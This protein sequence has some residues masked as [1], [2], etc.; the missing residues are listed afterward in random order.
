MKTSCMTN[1]LKKLAFPLVVCGVLCMGS[2]AR[3]QA[4][5]KSISTTPGLEN[6][7]LYSAGSEIEIKIG[8][9]GHCNMTNTGPYAFPQLRVVVNGENSSFAQMKAPP[10]YV[11][12]NRT[13]FYFYYKVLPGDMASPLKIY[14]QPSGYDVVANGYVFYNMT[15]TSNLVWKFDTNPLTS[16]LGDV[17]DLDFTAVAK[18]T[19]KTLAYDDAHSPVSVAATESVSWRVT[20]QNAISNSV[21]SF[22]VWPV[23]TNLVRVGSVPGQKA[24]LVSMPVGTTFVDFP[25][26]GLATGTTDIVAQRV[27]DY[28][29]SATVA[30]NA[31]TRTITVTVPPEPTVKVLFAGAETV[32]LPESP[33]LNTGSLTVELSQPFAQ[34]VWVRL[35]TTPSVQTNVAFVPAPYIVRVLAGSLASAPV[36]FSLPDGTVASLASGIVITP[37]VTNPAAASLFTRMKPGTVYVRNVKPTIVTPQPLV[38][39]PTVTRGEPYAFNWSVSDVPLDM[40]SGMTLVWNFGDGTPNVIVSNATGSVYHT[41][42]SPAVGTGTRTVTVTATDKDGGVSDPVIYN[43]TVVQPVPKPSVRIV[44]SAFTYDETSTNNTGSLNLVLSEAFTEDVWIQLTTSPAGQSNIV[45]GVTNAIRI[46]YGFLTNANP[47]KFSIP[48]GTLQSELAGIDIIPT[49]TNTLA[50]AYYTD[51]QPITLYAVNVRPKVDN[52]KARDLAA[53][54]L[55]PFNN[56]PM[57][58]P[59]AFSWTVADVPADGPTM[60]ISWLFDSGVTQ[61]TKTGT[62]LSGVVYPVFP[63][64]GD[65]TVTMQATDKDGGVSDAITFKITVTAPPPLPTVSIIPPAGPLYETD[66]AFTGSFIVHL[67]ETFTNTVTVALGVSPVNSLANGTLTLF[68]NR[69]YIAAGLQ[70]ATVRF[71]AKDGTV[72]SRDSGFIVTPTV[73]A[74]PAAV[75]KY[76]ETLTGLIQIINVAPVITTPAP[77]ATTNSVLS[78]AQGAPYTFYWNVNDVSIDLPG[79]LV[80]WYFGDGATAVMLG[81]S[82]QVAHTYTAVGDMV[83]RVVAQDKDGERNEVQFR[84]TVAQA[85]AINVT[86]IGPNL[87]ANYY[88]AAGLGNGMV[89]SG[90]ARS[91]QNRNNTYFFKYDPGITQ[92][93]LEAVPYKTAPLG[94]YYVTNFNNS[95]VAVV[96]TAQDLFDSFFYVWVGGTEQGLGA[97]NCVPGTALP[98][99]VVLMPSS[100]TGGTGTVPA[101]VDIREIS[102][103]F[104]REWRIADNMGDIN[105]DGIPDKIATRYNLPTLAGGTVVGGTPVELVNVKNF[106]S[107]VDAAGNVVGDFLPGAASGG[108]A[109][110]GGLSNV[111]ATI[112]SPFTALLEIRGFHPGLNSAGDRSDEDFGPGEIRGDEPGTDPTKTDTDGDL[113]PDGWEYYFWYHSI[114]EHATGLAYNPLDVSVGTVIPYKDIIIAFDPMVHAGDAVR[115]DLDNDGLSDLEELAMGTNPIN[116]DTD[117]D[118][119]CDGWEVLRG[120]NPNDSRD[121][122]NSSMNNPDGDYMAITT[123]PRQYVT[124]VNGTTTN[125][126]LATGA[127]IGSTSGVFTTWYHYGDTNA[128][129]AVGRLVTLAAGD[130]V[131]A[132]TTNNVLIMH[133]QVYQEFGFDP[134]TAWAGTVNPLSNPQRFPAW[135]A[136]YTAENYVTAPNTQPFTALDEYLLLKYMSELRLNGATAAM[137]AGN[138]GQKT[139]DWTSYSTHPKTPDSDVVWGAN[140]NV[141]KTDRMPDGWEMYVSAPQGWTRNYLMISPWDAYDGEWTIVGEDDLSNMREFHGTDCSGGYTNIALYGA[142]NPVVTIIRP[143]SD[144][145]WINKF[146]PTSPWIGDTDGD[147]IKDDAEMTFIYGA[148]P[149]VDNGTTCTPGGG[150]NPNTMDTDLDSLPDGWENAFVGTIPTAAPYSI[151]NGMDG[152]VSDYN[153][154]WDADGLLNYQEYW[155]QAVRGFRYDIPDEGVIGAATGNAGLPMDITFAAVDLF[156][157]VTNVWDAARKPWGANGPTLYVMLQVGP[158]KLYVGT[159][160]RDPDSDG[161]GMDDH[162]EMFHGLN[163]VLGDASLV[164]GDIVANAYIRNGGYTIDYGGAPLF[165]GNDW[166]GPL[167]PLDFMT[168]PWLAG[169]PEAD[170]DADGLRNLEEKLQPNTAAPAYS[171]TDPSPIW[172]TDYS[173]PE[174][175]TARFYGY[176]G[177][178]FWPPTLPPDYL[179]SY[180]MNEGYDTDN[181]GVSD[182]A[183]MMQTATTK[184]DPQNHD[185]PLRRQAMWFSG[186][187]SAAQTLNAFSFGEWAFRSFTVE[188]WA[189]PEVVNRD[190]VLVERPITYGPSDLSTAGLAV[191]ENFRI[192]VAADGRVYAMFQNAGLHDAHTGVVYA[193]G[194]ALTTNQWVHLAARM[195]G[196]TGQFQLLVNGLVETTV[197]T[198]LIPANGVINTLMTPGFPVPNYISVNPGVIVVGAAN[199]NPGAAQPTWF[200]YEQ[201]FQGYVDEVRV[202]D[203]ARS[204]DEILTDYT[205]RYTNA[206]LAKNRRAVR[207]SQANG[208]SR[209]IGSTMP[210][211]AELMYHYTFDN[212][213]SADNSASV[214]K[215]PRGF[216]DA[217]VAINRPFGTVVGWW[218]LLAT[219]ST[220]YDDYGYIPWIENGVEH[221]PFFGGVRV[222]GTPP[223]VWDTNTVRNSVYYSHTASG[224][225]A[226]ENFFPNSNDPYG[227]WYGSA[228]TAGTGVFVA[229][230]LLPLGDAFAKQVVAMWDNGG[231][232]GNWAETGLDTDSDG[233]PDWWE[234]YVA[235]LY[236][237]STLGWYDLYPDGSGMTAGERYMRDLANGYTQSNNPN[238]PGW[239]PSTLVKQTADSDG[240]GMPD[241]WENLYNLKPDVG[242]GDNGGGGDLDRDGLSNYAEYLISERYGFRL[243]RPTKFRTNATQVES[244]YFQKQGSLYLGEMFSDHDF[245]EDMWEDQY[246]P[247]YVSRFVYDPADDADEDGWSNWAECRFAQYSAGTRPDLSMRTE[248][249][250]LMHYEFPIPTVETTIRYNGLQTGGTVVLQT[251]TKA[252]MDG[253]PDATFTIPNDSVTVTVKRQPLGYWSDKI[254]HGRL[255]PGSIQPG[256]I[257]FQFTDLWTDISADT[258][259]DVNGILYAGSVGGFSTEIGTINY[260]TGEFELSLSYYKDHIILLADTIQTRE[261]YIDCMLSFIQMTYSVRAI[262]TWPKMAY[263]GYADQG[264]VREGTNYFF[265]FLDVSNNGTWDAGEPCGVSEGFGVDVGFDYNAINIGLTDITPDYLRMTLAPARRSEEVYYGTVGTAAGGTG[266]GGLESRVRVRRKSVDGSVAYT[267]VVLDKWISSTR[268]SIH[269][270]DLFEQGQFGLDWGMTNVSTTLNRNLLVYEVFTGD[271]PV[272]TNAVLTFT[273]TY[274]FVRAKAAS[275]YPVN[276]AYVYSSRP[277]FKWRMPKEYTAFTL[278]IKKGSAGGTVVYNSGTVIAPSRDVDGNCVWTAPIHAGNRIPSSGQIFSSNSAYSWRVMAMN[279]KFSD[280]TLGAVWS[281]SKLFRLDVN[282][283]LDSSGYGAIQANVKYYGPAVNLLTNR[284]KVQAFR[285]ASFTGVPE[286]EYTLAGSALAAMLTPGSTNVNAVLR[287]LT[288]SRTAG[289]YYIRAFIDHNQN[290]VRDVWESW[291]YA[292]YYGISD[293]PYDPYP[294]TVEYKSQSVVYDI[295]IEDADS[296]QDWYPDAWEYEQNPTGDF[297]NLTGP[298]PATNPDTEVNPFLSLTTNLGRTGLSLFSAGLALTTSDAD[299]DG[300][301]D[302]MELVLGTNAGAASTTG[303]GYSDGAKFN[304]GISPLDTLS[305][306]VTGL[307]PGTDGG[308][309][310]Q[311][312]LKVTSKAA[313]TSGSLLSTTSSTGATFEIQYRE[314]LSEGTWTPVGTCPA[315][316]SGVQTALGVD[317]SRINAEKGF[318]RVKLIP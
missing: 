198:T 167:L 210:L 155:V 169:L 102:A 262:S 283:P 301:S 165:L 130:V 125:F 30:T 15:T 105:N 146:W 145:A 182:K 135:V 213:F 305:F 59:F 196:A 18:R 170:P 168:Y 101:S 294:I 124:V 61:I 268:T 131:T 289:N 39:L 116:W 128:T 91:S 279:S 64:M 276:G 253:T 227:I 138:A 115:R 307:N 193:Y 163:P 284:V 40:A 171:N 212:L 141:S 55:P 132:L 258:G 183:E 129:I 291:G 209:V 285:N 134:R 204:N 256:T 19:I 158:N 243:S 179:F 159:D 162:Y 43:V 147:G 108:G 25:I 140:G 37:S 58:T 153:K 57:G 87:E 74:T 150:L 27:N 295:R 242:A 219:R 49:V 298:S 176:G 282:Q 252:S 103:I 311:W 232:S 104:S 269:E 28:N 246:D 237:A 296:D 194:R 303:D 149:V 53:A 68:T 286:A 120:L 8:M 316:F 157:Q 270:G 17:Y 267:G 2:S 222:A 293:R 133:N 112:G 78:I 181:D 274:E 280:T 300:L 202:W 9:I 197:P 75:I 317:G 148:I 62:G 1:V 249:L 185:D 218:S 195:D 14:S 33:T 65:W 164:K 69:V 137:G 214:S 221:L 313:G 13:F 51:M 226:T 44:P 238:S 314:S 306:N 188:L 123:V 156:T 113:F 20:T 174:S 297:L 178:F 70:D 6:T 22:Y 187:N 288:P 217:Q 292:N 241:W 250:N 73:V 92:T 50:K 240:D 121:G 106:N 257:S 287:G 54:P 259:F 12:P 245:M 223:V 189:R 235:V 100:Q 29:A 118:G 81:G 272:F 126:Y 244:D 220:V 265:A 310:L 251:Y 86:P 85:K 264:Y 234:A 161:D 190:Q 3:A 107:D 136:G 173:N 201:F 31:I 38:P 66:T 290:T 97:P 82:G 160:P 191:R 239:N 184:S 166:G 152:T 304:L 98:S 215:E 254:V 52:P 203:G 36:P 117:G 114:M 266:T 143:S 228:S 211:Q 110:I 208:G 248:V 77:S 229:G 21:V 83:V 89:F 72:L 24:L 4:D 308:A 263:L 175:L 199:I 88:G 7:T 23:N 180:E 46:S 142:G 71:S 302:M 277:T 67:S 299:G 96:S 79:M 278:E 10:S 275:T 216:N 225:F 281:D 205:K 95:G 144:A 32:E 41:Y 318:F 207:V 42:L 94:Y 260:V 247:Y 127:D 186:Q 230:D 26:T 111:F 200:D 233:L 139:A 261:D 309:V 192:G 236:P 60:A 34:D 84:I 90:D 93:T 154:D 271:S 122:L 56:V 172:M 312:L 119:M 273:N 206:D 76:T 48:D 109:I 45:F 47:I 99:A 177:M 315:T 63:T 255:S 5:I 16:I 80:T 11:A 35:N 151:T 231:A 224:T